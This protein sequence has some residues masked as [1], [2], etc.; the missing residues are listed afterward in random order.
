MNFQTSGASTSEWLESTKDMSISAYVEQYDPRVLSFRDN[1]ILNA[2]NANETW[3]VTDLL[4][5]RSFQ[6]ALNDARYGNTQKT[7]AV[8]TFLKSL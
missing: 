5:K 1:N 4:I 7:S 6:R 3:I 8:D 2:I